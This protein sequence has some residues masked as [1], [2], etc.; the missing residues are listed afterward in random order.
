MH[1]FLRHSVHQQTELSTSRQIGNAPAKLHINKW[2]FH[3]KSTFLF[4]LC[5]E[6]YWQAHSITQYN[7]WTSKW[8]RLCNT[9]SKCNEAIVTDLCPCYSQFSMVW[10]IT[11]ICSSLWSQK[12]SEMQCCF[13]S[14]KHV[15]T[16]NL[17]SSTIHVL[18]LCFRINMRWCWLIFFW[19]FCWCNSLVE[20]SKDM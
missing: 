12:L 2:M 6:P 15:C 18:S 7:C 4:S 5:S 20:S 10:H 3:C 9:K 13:N 1:T 8:H 17:L 11:N 19:Y 14:D 16:G